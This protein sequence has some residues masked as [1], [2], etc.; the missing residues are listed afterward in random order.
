[1]YRRPGSITII[2]GLLTV[3]GFLAALSALFHF[4]PNEAPPGESPQFANVAGVAT[5]IDAIV[6]FVCGIGILKGANWARWVYAVRY[7]LFLP[8]D[9]LLLSATTVRV[10]P[11]L[12]FETACIVFL[13][14][15][16]TNRFFSREEC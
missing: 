12:I 7:A 6:T 2:G 11:A 3:F 1:M 15:P 4:S 16:E 9:F 10:M 5:I 8:V 13:F 14:L